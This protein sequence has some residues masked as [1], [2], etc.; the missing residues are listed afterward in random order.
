MRAGGEGGGA[1]RRSPRPRHSAPARG[2]PAAEPTAEK[3][4]RRHRGRPPRGAPPRPTVAG[5]SAQRCR[6]RGRAASGSPPTRGEGGGPAQRAQR[7]PCRGHAAA[8]P[9]TPRCAH[10]RLRAR[11]A[12]PAASGRAG[13]QLRGSGEDAGSRGVRCGSAR[14]PSSR[15]RAGGASRRAARPGAELEACTVRVSWSSGVRRAAAATRPSSVRPAQQLGAPRSR[16]VPVGVL[17]HARPAAAGRRPLRRTRCVLRLQAGPLAKRVRSSSARQ[18]PVRRRA[19]GQVDSRRCRD[20]VVGAGQRAAPPDARMRRPRRNL[21]SKFPAP[22]STCENG[23]AVREAQRG[24]LHAH[25]ERS[26]LHPHRARGPRAPTRCRSRVAEPRG[27]SS[28]P[29]RKTRSAP[30]AQAAEALDADRA[31]EAAAARHRT[32][33]APLAAGRGAERPWKRS[34]ASRPHSQRA[35]GEAARERAAG[36]RGSRARARSESGAAFSSESRGERVG[37]AS[38]SGGM[39]SHERCPAAA[40]S[41]GTRVARERVAAAP[42]RRGRG[43]RQERHER[44]R[45]RPSGGAGS[46]R[47]RR[48]ASCQPARDSTHSTKSRVGTPVEPLIW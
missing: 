28:K 34:S 25:P 46:P 8:H 36:R 16:S 44:R 30:A 31:A 45:A 13:A 47:E 6:A 14:L 4:G 7:G 40:V 43:G 2:H 21:V 48:Q 27:S 42:G 17:R 20:E 23:C 37:L 38:C 41:R 10:A 29:S 32:G 15:S 3:S 33:R 19:A 12:R 24:E 35:A 26:A 39:G 9:T 22:A 5:Y 1:E 18:P 11:P